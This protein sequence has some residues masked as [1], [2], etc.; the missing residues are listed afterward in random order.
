MTKLTEWEADLAYQMDEIRSRI[1]R[2]EE[3]AESVGSAAG[4]T[5]KRPVCEANEPRLPC[6]PL[7][8][9]VERMAEAFRKACVPAA[10]DVV[11]AS[12]DGARA[13]L[14]V[15][16]DGLLVDATPIEQKMPVQYVINARL[17][18]ALEACR[19]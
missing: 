5:G 15:A 19:G 4:S 9:L 18:A 16:A 13:A 11:S 1:A 7:D 3:R 12:H 2:L 6:A 8:S 10:F 17:A 14:R